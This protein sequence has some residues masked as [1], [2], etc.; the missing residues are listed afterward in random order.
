M[1]N[2]Y[3]D[4]EDSMVPERDGGG[5]GVVSPCDDILG[6]HHQSSMIMKGSTVAAFNQQRTVVGKL[7]R[8]EIE[9]RYLRLLEENIVL[10]KHAVKQDEKIKKLA[11][12]LIR[13]MSDKKRLEMGKR[14]FVC[15]LFLSCLFTKYRGSYIFYVDGQGPNVYFTVKKSPKSCLRRKWM[16]PKHIH[17]LTS[18][19][20][21]LIFQGVVQRLAPYVAIEIL[22]LKN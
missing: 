9:D 18:Y 2:Y 14:L 10:K 20:I 21:G 7:S 17:F 1:E 11:T 12:K 6:D 15:L 22:K 19:N 5:G 4:M 8:G 3:D 13:V 16:T